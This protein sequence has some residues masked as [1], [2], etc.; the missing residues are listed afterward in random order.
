MNLELPE[1]GTEVP[2]HVGA[3][4]GIY[5]ELFNY[6]QVHLWVIYYN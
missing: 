6:P 2:K 4:I 3:F 5:I 1:D